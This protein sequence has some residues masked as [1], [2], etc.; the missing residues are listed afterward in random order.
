MTPTIAAVTLDWFVWRLEQGAAVE[1]ERTETFTVLAM[2]QWCNML[3]CQ[4][5]TRSA[6]RFTLVRNPWLLGGPTLSIAL[7]ALVL[8]APPMNALFHTVPLEPATLWPL[9]ALASMVL[10]VEEVRKAVVRGRART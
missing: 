6:L 4:S 7:Q 2:R 3:N 1:L 8:Y 5:A 10:R 9:V